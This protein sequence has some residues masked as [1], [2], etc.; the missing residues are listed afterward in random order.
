MGSESGSSV[1]RKK[2]VRASTSQG[3]SVPQNGE[4]DEGFLGEIILALPPLSHFPS[5]SGRKMQDKKW[6][7]P[8]FLP[9][10]VI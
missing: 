3:R 6:H 1:A 5:L 7:L 8:S 2:R 10:L 9:P 4:M